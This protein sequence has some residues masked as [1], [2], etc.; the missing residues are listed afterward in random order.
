MATHWGPVYH[1]A[2][3][4]AEPK[5]L[6]VSE[7]D[8]QMLAYLSQ[9]RR[10]SLPFQVRALRSSIAYLLLDFWFVPSPFRPALTPLP[11]PPQEQ[12][13]LEAF[14]REKRLQGLLASE[15]SAQQA[16]HVADLARPLNP[17]MRPAPAD[18][19]AEEGEGASAAALV[20]PTGSERVSAA[21]PA[22]GSAGRPGGGTPGR[23]R[24]MPLPATPADAEAQ[25]VRLALS[26]R[27][28]PLFVVPGG[29]SYEQLRALPR[30]ADQQYLVSRLPCLAPPACAP[31]ASIF[32]GR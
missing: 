17:R 30:P 21:A 16:A 23:K 31:G 7:P 19:A 24:S 3:K 12:K 26:S 6:P 27:Y 28:E 29:L 14:E 15:L 10:Y 1:E 4:P 8:A 22:G 5:P 9:P 32:P 18:G 25:R 13:Q 20:S 2:P 11:V